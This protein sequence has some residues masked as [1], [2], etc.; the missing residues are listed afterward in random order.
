MERGVDRT[1]RGNHAV[2]CRGDG[3]GDGDCTLGREVLGMGIRFG[4]GGGT[5]P[6]TGGDNGWGGGVEVVEIFPQ[7][8]N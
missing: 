6:D 5:K 1:G 2:D 3:D 8:P 4:N 7:G